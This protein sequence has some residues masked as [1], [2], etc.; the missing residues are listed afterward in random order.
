MNRFGSGAQQGHQIMKDDE[1]QACEAASL[2]SK[3]EQPWSRGS[4][5]CIIANTFTLGHSWP[6]PHARTSERG[7]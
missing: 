2:S 4:A 3:Q 1:G 5:E 7:Y 6:R